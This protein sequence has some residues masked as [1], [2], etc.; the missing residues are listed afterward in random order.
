MRPPSSG[1]VG[2]FPP[3]CSATGVLFFCITKTVSSWTGILRDNTSVLSAPLGEEYVGRDS[4]SIA[5][6]SNDPSEE[7]DISMLDLAGLQV[8]V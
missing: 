1:S 6:G 7:E 4:L 2:V 3:M 5:A 8:H